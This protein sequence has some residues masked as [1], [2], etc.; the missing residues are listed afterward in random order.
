M[1]VWLVTH[2][3]GICTRRALDA[4]R[5]NGHARVAQFLRQRLS[6]GALP[7]SLDD[8]AMRSNLKML[9][10]LHA[11]G[12]KCSSRAMDWAAYNCNLSIIKFLHSERHEGCTVRA[13][14]GAAAQGHYHIVK[15]LLANRHEGFTMAAITNAST[16][17]IKEL[18]VRS[19]VPGRHDDMIRQVADQCTH[20]VEAA[21][22][23]G[24]GRA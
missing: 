14:D 2:R 4:A 21:G 12:A 6:R 7:D 8:A 19:L 5:R 11:N 13:I 18:L 16:P 23:V 15:W 20:A 17:Y 10:L 1:V 22:S 9:R 3:D 24:A